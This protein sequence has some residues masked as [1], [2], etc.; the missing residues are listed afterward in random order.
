MTL[1]RLEE[2]VWRTVVQ[3][4]YRSA[5]PPF[6]ISFLSRNRLDRGDDV[7]Q[8]G[9]LAQRAPGRQAI[10][11]GHRQNERALVRLEAFEEGFEPVGHRWAVAAGR[12]GGYRGARHP[13]ACAS[14]S[15]QNI[16]SPAFSSTTTRA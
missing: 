6:P 11:L 10:M 8:L 15:E 1:R 5:A 3:A 12:A 9:D 2:L 14:V 13:A 7:L 4:S 16:R